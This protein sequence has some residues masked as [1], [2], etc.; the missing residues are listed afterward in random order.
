MNRLL[1]IAN[2]DYINT[3]LSLSGIEDEVKTIKDK[4][5]LMQ[6]KIEIIL[7]IKYEEIRS[8]VECFLKRYLKRILLL[9]ITQGMVVIMMDEILLYVLIPQQV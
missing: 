8:K 7:N 3:A 1:L 2:Y 6:Y 9:F 4:F 5:E